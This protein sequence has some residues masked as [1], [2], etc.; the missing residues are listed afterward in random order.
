MD[1]Y[2]QVLVEILFVP[3]IDHVHQE[4]HNYKA[5]EFSEESWTHYHTCNVNA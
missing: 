3:V 4:A 1:F 5:C 2:Q